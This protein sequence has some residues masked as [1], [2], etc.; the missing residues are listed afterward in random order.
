MTY[1]PPDPYRQGPGY[2]DSPE[3]EEK[4]VVD[5]G[6]LWSGGVA[7]AIVAALVALVGLL[8]ARGLLDIT[9][10]TRKSAGS[11]DAASAIPYALWAAAGALLAT[12]LMHLLLLTTPRPRLFFGWI[13][14][15]VAVVF[16]VQ[17]FTISA[18]LDEKIATAVIAVVIV[19]AIASLV[20]GTAQRSVRYVRV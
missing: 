8:I 2:P 11:W 5:A 3:P 7:T 19:I 9:V 10:L 14:A 20:A 1:P 13:M 18:G 4:V 17:P 12:G 16:A 15:L 6:K